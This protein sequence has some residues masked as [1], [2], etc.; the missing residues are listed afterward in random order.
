MEVVVLGIIS[1]VKMTKVTS[2]TVIFTS[3]PDAHQSALDYISYGGGRLGASR[4]C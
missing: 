3:Q 1:G 4:I 2:G